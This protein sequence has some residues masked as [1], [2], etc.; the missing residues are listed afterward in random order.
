MKG[1]LEY[2]PGNTFLH[3][4]NPVVKL[5]MAL[6]LCVA[7]FLSQSIRFALSMIGLNLI[8]AAYAGIGRR[9]LS[10]LKTLLKLG[11]FLFVLQIL[12][13]RSGN[14]L[15]DLPFGFSITDK[16]LAFSTLLVLRLIGA[17][18]PL[19]LLLSLT[20]M[21]D[22]TGALVQQL[23]IPYRYAFALTT[24]IRFIP[25]FSHEMSAIIEAQTARGVAFDTK[26]PVK[27]LRLILPLCVPLL[28]SSVK[29]CESAAISAELRGFGN[30][31]QSSGYLHFS[32]SFADLAAVGACVILLGA[33]CLL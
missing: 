14:V 10:M 29:K 7:C 26:N 13:I 8:M 18:M 2:S 3:R 15:L 28:V 25:V 23:R 33:G 1:M 9:A 5:L 17:T 4:I 16:G 19:A 24:A 21:G 20:R 32:V 30:R 6:L 27:K 12:F 22:L 31:D 11:I